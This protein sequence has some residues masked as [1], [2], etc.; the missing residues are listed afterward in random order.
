MIYF[1]ALFDTS[2][3]TVCLPPQ[4]VAAIVQKMSYV[5]TLSHLSASNCM[6]LIGTMSSCIPMLPWAHWHLRIFQVGFLAQWKRKSL[7]Q[8]ILISVSMRR[9]LLWWSKKDLISKPCLLQC[10]S[11]TILTTDASSLGWGGH[12]DHL[13][14]QGKWDFPT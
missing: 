11:W 13:A 5:R 14:I 2:A 3:G 12:C 7:C 10:P 4:K 6:S 9:G 1:G 8:Q